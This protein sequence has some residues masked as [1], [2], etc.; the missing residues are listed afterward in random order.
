MQPKLNWQA[1][2]SDDRNKII[3]E[4][5]ECILGNDAYIVNFNLFSDYALSLSIEVSENQI[6][7][8]YQALAKITTISEFDAESL[9]KHSKKE[10]LVFLNISFTNAQG[11]LKSIIPEVPG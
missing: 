9:S 5:K 2:S 7:P 8:L 10:W 1:F 3:A 11:K 6:L 4:I